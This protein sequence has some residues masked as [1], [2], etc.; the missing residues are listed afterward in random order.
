[1][2]KNKIPKNRSLADMF[3]GVEENIT[4]ETADWDDEAVKPKKRAL[5]VKPQD[6]AAGLRKQFFTEDLQTK[7]GALLLEIKLAYY[8]DGVGDI[9][10]EVVK[11][12]RNI[13]IKTKPK[14]GKRS[15]AH[16]VEIIL[17]SIRKYWFLSTARH[18]PDWPWSMPCIWPAK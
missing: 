3:A 16:K 5:S 17:R 8:K 10:L 4:F 6:K 12:G 11:D 9:S 18:I 1:M 14:A 2:G 15:A 7:V 13:V